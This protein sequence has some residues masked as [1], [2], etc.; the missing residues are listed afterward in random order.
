MRNYKIVLV[1]ELK[2]TNT[3]FH[4]S[5]LVILQIYQLKEQKKSLTSIKSFQNF[6]KYFFQIPLNFTNLSINP[7]NLIIHTQSI[8]IPSNTF[9]SLWC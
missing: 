6:Y 1:N 8:Q 9:S 4:K 3:L 2:I 7:N 5:Q